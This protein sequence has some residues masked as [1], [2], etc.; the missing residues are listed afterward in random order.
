VTAV[1]KDCTTSVLTGIGT[2]E[3]NGMICTGVSDTTVGMLRRGIAGPLGM[4]RGTSGG[5]WE[6]MRLT[7]ISSRDFLNCSTAVRSVKL[8]TNLE[9]ELAL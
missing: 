1:G 3:G 9:A 8:G 4:V 7:F 5:R 6:M 2:T